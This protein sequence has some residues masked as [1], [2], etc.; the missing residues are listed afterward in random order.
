MIPNLVDGRQ[1]GALDRLEADLVREL[2]QRAG[3]RLGLMLYGSVARG[4]NGPQ[5]DVDIL[6]LVPASA[7]S[8]QVGNANITSYEVAHLRTLAE[9][10][11]LFV[12]H[13]LHDGVILEDPHGVLQRTL[14]A[15][16]Q[17]ST[18][19][20]LW[21]QIELAGAALDPTSLDHDRY[22]N[23]LVRLGLYLLRTAAY[24]R[25]VE[26]GE[27]NF[28][29]SSRRTEL[30][31]SVTA[32]LS[33]RHKHTFDGADVACIRAALQTLVPG[34]QRNPHS[35]IEALAVTFAGDPELA[36]LLTS[37]LLADGG[38][39]YSALTLPPL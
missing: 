15:Y 8:F 36:P 31:S 34:I 10:G 33:I 17:P 30:D 5:S 18:Y 14:N 25:G 19:A 2:E 9:R 12:L 7:K 37:V 21:A 27:I 28:D 32:A 1:P 29:L 3:G 13:L 35:T 24:L 23:G 11:S 4:S 6:E 20:P 22:P 38:V 39:D 26:R 16:R